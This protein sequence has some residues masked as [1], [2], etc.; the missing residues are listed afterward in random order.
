MRRAVRF[1][2]IGLIAIGLAACARSGPP[3]PVY[4]GSSGQPA[5]GKSSAVVALSAISP[6]STYVVR[7]GDTLYTIA[8]RSGVPTRAIID[9]NRLAPPYTLENGT[10]LSIPS[11]QTYEVKSGDTVSQ[12]ALRFGVPMRELVRANAIEPPYVIR[13][14]QKLILPETVQPPAVVA[15]NQPP[16]R[17]ASAPRSSVE[18]TALPAPGQAP[19]PAETNTPAPTVQLPSQPVPSATP[20]PAR[21][22]ASTGTPLPPANPPAT[23]PASDVTPRIGEGRM[24]WPVRGVIVSDFG[25]KAGGLQNDGINIAAPRGTAFRAAENG[26]VIY[27]GNELRGFGNLLLI[28]HE[29]GVVTAYA[30]ADEIAVQRGDQVRRGQTL[31]RVGSTGN[32]TSPQLHFEVRRG[33]RAVNPMDFLGTQTSAAN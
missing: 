23:P 29:G 26:T 22:E 2:Q 24:Q 13:I 4:V 20:E 1:A 30:H 16:A 33:N 18:S 5:Q 8:R 19:K 3:A 10:R 25:P 6:G 21:Q 11:V 12:I 27:A 9:V 31:G 32:V 14:G 15:A 7:P 17:I 28:R